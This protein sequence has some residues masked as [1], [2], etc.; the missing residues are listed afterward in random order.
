MTTNGMATN[1]ECFCGNLI[2]D[3]FAC[4]KCGLTVIGSDMKKHPETDQMIRGMIE[5]I[6]NIDLSI[7]D[8]DEI[9]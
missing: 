1:W 7:K 8:K 9:P 3:A 5:D 6:K 4:D 2:E